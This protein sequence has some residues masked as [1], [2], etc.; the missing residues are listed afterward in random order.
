MAAHGGAPLGGPI[1]RHGDEPGYAGQQHGV[2]GSD[3]ASILSRFA[4]LGDEHRVTRRSRR[5]AERSSRHRVADEPA[6]TRGRHASSEVDLGLLRVIER[7]I[8]W[9]AT[10]STRPADTGRLAAGASAASLMTALWF[11]ALGGE[12]R[13]WI[14]P[15]TEPLL[16]AV[17]RLFGD[18]GADWTDECGA[19][20]VVS[21]PTGAAAASVWGGLA[22]RYVD[23]RFGAAAGGS[24]A[25]PASHDTRDRVG[26]SAR[27][28]SLVGLDDLSDGS[29]WSAV[30]D[31]AAAELGEVLW[32]VDVPRRGGPADEP[33]PAEVARLS[34]IFTAAGWQVLTSAY[35]TVLSQLFLEP[36]GDAL[37]ERI[38]R[39]DGTDYATLLGLP[40]DEIRGWLPGDGPRRRPIA[41]LVE[42]LDDQL[43]HSAVRD[44][45][46]HDLE[47][48][49]ETF[50]GLAEDRPTV[51]FAHTIAGYGL[52]GEGVESDGTIW[53][54]RQYADLAARLGG[55]VD[56]PW[57]AFPAGSPESHWCKQVAGRL[58]RSRAHRPAPP[59]PTD[60]NR[61][62][63]GIVST[64]AAVG[65]TVDE[66][67]WSAPEVTERV[68]ACGQAWSGLSGDRTLTAGGPTDQLLGVLGELGVHW[69]LGGEPVLPVG[70][71]ESGSVADTAVWARGTAA[72]S[73]SILLG[74]TGWTPGWSGP[75]VVAYEPAFAQD[76]EW[77]LLRSLGLLGMPGGASAYLRISGRPIDQRLA[78]VPPDP[79]ARLRRRHAAV[80]GGYLLRPAPA[81]ASGPLVTLAA[82]GRVLPE[83]LAGADLLAD[84]GV[85]ARVVCVTSADLLFRAAQSRRG[86]ARAGSDA[87]AD[88]GLLDELFP[89]PTPTVTVSDG[90]AQSLAFL[91]GIQ[92]APVSCLGEEHLATAGWDDGVPL[93][94]AAAAGM[95]A[96]AA[97]DLVD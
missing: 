35:G 16:R 9:L 14:T 13:V 95:V 89:E 74:E 75:D 37:R 72:G 73:Q 28:I 59:V 8:L 63:D 56:D 11:E 31:P 79:V 77:C 48:L 68:V 39:L 42:T 87:L 10:S 49:L 54:R 96:G 65:L 69:R 43:L 55:V 33:M 46:G 1:P 23:G 57:A 21:P 90:A 82:T 2:P 58:R 81:G 60:L 6:S 97:L 66:L 26:G 50:G 85:R 88:E 27:Q 45:G 51:L 61:V 5:E 36:G 24:H 70:V 80:H 94:S 34:D 32:I 92:P 40:A 62:R 12:D 84:Y 91:G 7:R 64:Q 83:V 22:H 93:A 15:R 20:W 18:A 53:T 3:V 19:G 67:R 25:A 76:L 17:T 71:L 44:L 29:C 78:A 41:R 38:Q 52:P 47:G 86:L 4:G 30:R